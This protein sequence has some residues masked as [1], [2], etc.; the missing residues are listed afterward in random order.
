[1]TDRPFPGEFEELILLAT[2]HL[3]DG[4]YGAAIVRELE[5]R[6]DRTVARTSIYV[7]LDRL[8]EKGWIESRPGEATPERGGRPPRMITV[9]EAGLAAI[10]RA[11]AARVALW[12]GLDEVLEG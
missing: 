9:T 12:D 10:R 6:T 2:L 1:M 7:T 4:A 3:A 11:R 8:E 5:A